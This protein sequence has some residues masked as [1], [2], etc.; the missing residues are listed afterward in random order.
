MIPN[1]QKLNRFFINATKFNYFL[2]LFTSVN[3]E[4]CNKTIHHPRFKNTFLLQKNK[5]FILNRI[6]SFVTNMKTH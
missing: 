1:N 3:N 2:R 6:Y 4:K 5:G